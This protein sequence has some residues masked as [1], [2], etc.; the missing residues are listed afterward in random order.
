[1]RHYV[2]KVDNDSREWDNILDSDE[3]KNIGQNARRYSKRDLR[4]LLKEK[5]EISLK[6][7]FLSV[8]LIEQIKLN[9]WPMLKYAKEIIS[10]VYAKQ[11]YLAELSSLY[12][13]RSI[14]VENQMMEWLTNIDMRIYAVETVYRKTGNLT[15]GVDNVKLTRKNM[16]LQLDYLKSSK[17]KRHIPSDL[18]YI[19][20]FKGSKNL[21]PLGISTIKDRVIQTLFVQVLEPVIDVHSDFFEFIHPLLLFIGS[22]VSY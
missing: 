14:Q 20:I 19:S 2:C 10:L 6:Q 15:S 4:N 21:K 17:L 1:M 12:G 11:K 7:K 13:L 3:L 16:L 5:K 8:L 22:I 18:R 9:K